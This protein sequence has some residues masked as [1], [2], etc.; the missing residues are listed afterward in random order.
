MQDPEH[1][2][3]LNE[4]SVWLKERIKEHEEYVK[5]LNRCLILLAVAASFLIATVYL[6]YKIFFEGTI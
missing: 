6:A 4:H 2:D 3:L 5:L 1:K